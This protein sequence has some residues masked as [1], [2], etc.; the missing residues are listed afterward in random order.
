[1]ETVGDFMLP[2]DQCALVNTEMT[3]GDAIDALELA[4]DRQREGVGA[5]NY[6]ALLVLNDDDMVVG[7]LSYVDIV[8][9]M[10]PRYGSQQGSSAIAHM[11]AADLSPTLLKS[12]MQ[13][14]S[15]WD[16]PF[17]VRCQ[18]I[19]AAKVR[20]CMHT[21]GG[22]EYV[23][24]G[25]SLGLAVH[26][27]VMGHHQSLLVAEGDSVVGLLTL[28]DVFDRVRRLWRGGVGRGASAGKD[29]L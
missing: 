26:K 24:R 7:K 12:L 6:R 10:E 9:Y 16:Q 21:P 19:L 14:H 1:M 29:Q 11:F 28:T 25:D 18:E 17:E 8:M 20:D 22:D 13:R 4:H 3:L 27:L 5:C 23:H 2:V 15:F